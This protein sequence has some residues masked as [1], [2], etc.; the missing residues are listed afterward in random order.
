MDAEDQNHEGFSQEEC[1]EWVDRSVD[2][3][4]LTWSPH[5]SVTPA[6]LET[7]TAS[8]RKDSKAQETPGVA[9]LVKQLDKNYSPKQ[10]VNNIL[11]T[12]KVDSQDSSHNAPTQPHC[13]VV[14]MA[15][16]L[17]MRHRRRHRETSKAKNPPKKMK[18]TCEPNASKLRGRPRSS[19]SQVLTL[20]ENGDP[21]LVEGFDGVDFENLLKELDRPHT[22]PRVPLYP[23]EVNMPIKGESNKSKM[24]VS[25][26]K[27]TL[28]ENRSGSSSIATASKSV[29]KHSNARTVPNPYPK[30]PSVPVEPPCNAANPKNDEVQNR[31]PMR[32]AGP[33]EPSCS[34]V[35]K[36]S[37][38]VHSREEQAKQLM[39]P[40]VPTIA[41]TD[42]VTQ[43]IHNLHNRL[44][45]D[46]TSTL[47]EAKKE[48]IATKLHNP[49]PKAA[50]AN[51][52][53]NRRSK[54]MIKAEDSAQNRLVHFWMDE[55]PSALESTKETP[56][57]KT[58]FLGSVSPF[59]V[60]D[61]QLSE[62]DWAKMHALT[63]KAESHISNAPSGKNESH[64]TTDWSMIQA[65]DETLARARGHIS[66]MENTKNEDEFDDF[67]IFDFDALDMQIAKRSSAVVSNPA[68]NVRT[69]PSPDVAI[70]NPVSQTFDPHH[71]F[72]AF[73]RYK[74][75]RTKVDNNTYTKT[76]IVKEWSAVMLKEHEQKS[77]HHPS[78]LECSS[79]LAKLDANEL[80]PDGC[81]FLRGEW[82]HT[83]VDAGDVVHLCSLSGKY[84]T[85]LGALPVV[86][87]TNP[88]HGSNM[89]DDLVLV[90][91]PDLLIPPTAISE[92][93]SCS[94]RAVLR[95][96]LGSTGL[97]CKLLRNRYPTVMCP[98]PF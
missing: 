54:M 35:S 47:I 66:I 72:M 56:T 67:P 71:L 92:T 80:H 95:L 3:R 8:S 97:S 51:V 17:G 64:S 94:R 52:P 91:H 55:E 44:G 32:P 16:P 76:L 11:D 77:I 36:N 22:T 59:I 86:L 78:T 29:L 57:T 68:V 31:H 42:V 7:Q 27:V 24:K 62:E 4:Q 89:D 50:T 81:I 69:M 49:Y 60:D 88:P 61:L 28:M 73:S 26:L 1:V 13:N 37:Q 70:R 18:R 39:R 98:R 58:T 12:L 33:M 40:A 45:Q 9:E 23:A 79:S 74:V 53:M 10:E 19:G 87:H 90:V 63:I 93:M 20:T 34:A 6:L 30:R 38:N 85:D 82:Y 41:T 46:R 2:L 25:P 21:P 96:R 65:L 48:V 84:R 83:H 14:R 5:G 75:M 15:A 43:N